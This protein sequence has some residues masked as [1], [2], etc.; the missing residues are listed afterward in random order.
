LEAA[1]PV[2]DE[3]AP[4]LPGVALGV[5]L[6]GTTAPGPEGGQKEPR[7]Q[8]AI[9]APVQTSSAVG[10]QTRID[11]QREGQS[12]FVA[13]GGRLPARA[14]P[15]DHEPCSEPRQAIMDAA[16][17]RELLAAEDSPE[18]A[19]EEQHRGPATQDPSQ[20]VALAFRALHANSGKVAADHAILLALRT[21]YRLQTA[22]ATSGRF[23][24]IVA[25]DA[26]LREVKAAAASESSG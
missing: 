18:V 23:V 25:W 17:L 20:I 3:K 5:P 24:G 22:E 16:Q 13:D 6:T 19:N 11:E 8:G 14:T 4:E 12:H 10:S 15:D 1:A 2:E 7:I 9:P 21:S 26:R